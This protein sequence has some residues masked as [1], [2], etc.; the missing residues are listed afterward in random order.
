[1]PIDPDTLSSLATD[2]SA[3]MTSI[4]GRRVQRL[5]K[6]EFTGAE[7]AFA[8]RPAFGM[9][10]L[11]GLS[12]TGAAFCAT[13]GRGKRA[14]VAKWLHGSTEALESHYDLLK[15]S[16]P[17][18]ATNPLRSTWDKSMTPRQLSCIAVLLG[19]ATV[20]AQASFPTEFPQESAAMEAAVLKQLL[21]GK[22]FVV[23][24]V[25]GAPYRIQ[26]KDSYV[27]LNIGSTSDTGRWR[28]EGSS[29]CIEWNRLRA[30]CGEV[31]AAGSVLYVKR[32][33]NGE[34]VRMQEQ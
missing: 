33:S 21:T 18:L 22:T 9:A 16:L 26:Y 23:T 13:D 30:S 1:M 31:R 15:D 20:L 17:L 27:F 12:K 34:V 19:P 3:G 2:Y 4:R 28:T 8:V 10:A 24:P 6:R 32:A 5:L 25:G 11:L 29:V 14:S 7:F